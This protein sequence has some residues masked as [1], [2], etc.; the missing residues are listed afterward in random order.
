MSSATTSTPPRVETS[1]PVV[2][3]QATGRITVEGLGVAFGDNRRRR[4]AV[5]NVN[6]AIAP[7]EFV[8]LVGPSGCG[9]TTVLN[10][11]AGFLTPSTGRVLVDGSAV[12][13]ASA[14]RSVVFQQH[15]LFPWM[16]VIENIAFGPQMLGKSD[17]KEIARR[18]LAMVGLG[19]YAEAYP[20][21]LSGGMRQRVG[22]ARALAVEPPVLLMD[23]PFGALDALTRDLMQ[24]LLLRL[25]E[26]HRNTVVFITHDVDEAVFL[27]DRV[28]VMATR[29]GRVRADIRINLPRP[30]TAEMR[31][32]PEFTRLRREINQL[33]REESLRNFQEATV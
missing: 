24:E 20:A 25:W 26:K 19:D 21:A 4:A 14:Q 22:L 33:I 28:I 29:P 2:A 30:R 3:S 15:S 18:H 10:A 8:T 23:E 17:A 31:D 11:I 12:Q 32:L 9:K 27:S 1:P 6:L 7:G 13:G 5:E 16:T